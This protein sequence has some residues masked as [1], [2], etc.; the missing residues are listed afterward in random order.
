MLQVSPTKITDNKLKL[1]NSD[2]EEDNKE[3]NFDIR[4]QFEGQS[5]QL[6]SK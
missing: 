6:V 3:H 4:P 5:G 1:F 2:D